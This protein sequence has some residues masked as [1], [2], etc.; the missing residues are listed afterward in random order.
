[1]HLYHN[2]FYNLEYFSE[3]VSTTKEEKILA[4]AWPEELKLQQIDED[5]YDEEDYD[6]DYDEDDYDDDDYYDGDYDEDEY[7]DEQVNIFNS[8]QLEKFI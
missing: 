8:V 7:E 4:S 6:D 1:M 5:S 3:R 2:Q